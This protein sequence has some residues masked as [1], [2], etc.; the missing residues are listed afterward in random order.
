V[1]PEKKLAI[2]SFRDGV[3]GAADAGGGAAPV[4]AGAGGTALVEA[5]VAGAPAPPPLH[6]AS[7]NNAS[8][9]PAGNPWSLPDLGKARFVPRVIANLRSPTAIANS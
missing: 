2:L 6:P 9:A 5:V 3:L 1:A 4:D 8:A 7:N